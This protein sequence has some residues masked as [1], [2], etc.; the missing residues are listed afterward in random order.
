MLQRLG[1]HAGRIA[2]IIAA[3]VATKVE[4]TRRF[5]LHPPASITPP[6]SSPPP[7]LGGSVAAHSLPQ[8]RLRHSIALAAPSRLRNPISATPSPLPRLCRPS[9]WLRHPDSTALAPP[10]RLRCLGSTESAPLPRLCGPSFAA[11]S[12]LPYLCR[13]VDLP[14][15][16]RCHGSAATA[17]VPRL[18]CHGSAATAPLPRLR[19]HGSAATARP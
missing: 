7:P 18:S 2:V 9:F 13:S 12:P 6:Q 16:L 5:R 14:P 3:T 19:Y 1:C 10:L 15:R 8:N 17:L 11:S 4:P